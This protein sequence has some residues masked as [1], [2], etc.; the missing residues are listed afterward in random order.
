VF[1]LLFLLIRLMVA[2]VLIGIWLCFAA[3]AVPVMLL[4]AVT[5]NRAGARSLE[6]SLHWRRTF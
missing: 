3:I 5:G 1:G 6:R 2:V 4:C